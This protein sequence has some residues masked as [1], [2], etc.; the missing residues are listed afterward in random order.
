MEWNTNMDEAPKEATVTRKYTHHTSARSFTKSITSKVP[1]LISVNGQ[2][3][4][5]LWSTM[6]GTWSGI[7]D[8][9]VP[10]AWMAW[11]EPYEGE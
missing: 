3:I 10:D 9:E 6:R 4:E 5:S 11:P 8:D 1:V 7:S 2:V